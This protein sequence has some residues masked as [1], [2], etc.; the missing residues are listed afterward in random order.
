MV[1]RTSRSLTDSESVDAP[2][3]SGPSGAGGVKAGRDLKA[4]GYSAEFTDYLQE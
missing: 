1:T 4:T 3:S 2:S